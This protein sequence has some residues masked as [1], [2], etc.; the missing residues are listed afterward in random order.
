M[1]LDTKVFNTRYSF[2]SEQE[3]VDN[4]SCF[5][6]QTISVTNDRVTMNR[7]TNINHYEELVELEKKYL[8]SLGRASIACSKSIINTKTAIILF[9]LLIWPMVLYI[10]NKKKWNKIFISTVKEARNIASKA[11]EIFYSTN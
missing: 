1:A 9:L 6:W 4:Y 7:D 8:A 10:L 3:I 11:K 2:V 5:G